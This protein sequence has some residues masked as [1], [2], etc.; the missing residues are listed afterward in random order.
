M[1]KLIIV[2]MLLCASAF[3]Q[4]G[5]RVNPGPLTSTAV[6]NGTTVI[7]PK[8]AVTVQF[9][10]HP[11][12]ATPCTNKATTYT[13][14]TLGTP[15]ATSTQVVLD[16]TTTC[17]AGSDSIGNWGVWVAS[18]NYDWTFTDSGGNSFGPYYVTANSSPNTNVW[19]ALTNPT[20][21]LSLTMPANHVTT[22]TWAS[23]PPTG[24]AVFSLIPSGS[25]ALQIFGGGEVNLGIGARSPLS[26]TALSSWSGGTLPS[27]NQ[28]VCLNSTNLHKCTTGETSGALVG[29][30]AENCAAVSNMV[31][32]FVG[33]A[34]CAFDNAT[35]QGDWVVV[36]TTIA[37]D[38]HDTGSTT[39]PAT[40]IS[41]VGRAD[42][43]FGSPTTL[44]VLL[45]IAR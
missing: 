4:T 33:E 12:N 2:L 9:C 45:Q 35:T 30:C 22:F 28:L 18:A 43:T 41:T 21:S 26:F 11:A 25:K 16:G 34:I 36:S 40:S 13:D 14:A 19:S 27:Q 5:I 39:P 44:G 24:T 1:K 29:I 32:A 17:V 8:T 38:C 6:V 3:A 37:G 10:N 15:C 20:A 42:S 31:I 23:A 7:V